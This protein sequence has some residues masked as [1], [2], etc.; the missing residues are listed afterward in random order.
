MNMGHVFQIK[1]VCICW[2]THNN[3]CFLYCNNSSSH[4]CC[5]SLYTSLHQ[6]HR[7][8]EIYAPLPPSPWPGTQTSVQ[9]QS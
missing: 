5:L 1:Y 4:L 6:G 8:N 9:G 3:L 2:S 7:G